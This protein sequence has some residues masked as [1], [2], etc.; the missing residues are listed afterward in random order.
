MIKLYLSIAFTIAVMAV[1]AQ[2]REGMINLELQNYVMKETLGEVVGEGEL[3]DSVRD[4]KWEF[5][6]MYDRNIKY[7][8]G[9]YQDGVKSGT[10]NNY[11]LLPPMGYTN[12][13]DLI[14]S[15]EVWKNGMLFRFKMGQNNLLALIEDGLSEPHVSELRRLDESFENSYRRTHGKTYTPEYGETVE[16]LQARLI[17]MIRSVLIKSGEK[18]ELKEWTLGSKL[19]LHEKYEDGE[20]VYQFVQRWDNNVLYSSEVYE[21]GVMQ[22]KTLYMNGDQNNVISYRYFDSGEL[23]YMKHLKNDSIPI[24]KWIK[25]YPD[26]NKKYQGSYINGLREGKWK[27]WDEEGNMEVIKYK[28]GEPQ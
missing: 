1:N 14:R 20:I 13:Y 10:W 19:K 25:N 11:A 16:S 2:S 15:T 17:P 21:F 12:N 22:E 26:G 7:Y 18:A 6:L 9:Y 4:G 24:G 8:E 23:E 27:F 28:A 3:I 5:Y